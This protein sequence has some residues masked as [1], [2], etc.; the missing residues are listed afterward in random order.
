M[1]LMHRTNF[2]VKEQRVRLAGLSRRSAVALAAKFPE[3]GVRIPDKAGHAVLPGGF[4]CNRKMLLL[5]KKPL[6]RRR[7]VRQENMAAEATALRRES[8]A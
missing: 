7:T 8:P 6:G 5:H 4:L 3:R 2:P 1:V